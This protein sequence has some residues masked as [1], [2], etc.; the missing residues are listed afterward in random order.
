MADGIN[1]ILNIDLSQF[2]KDYKEALRK[3]GL[4]EV[5]N[6]DGRTRILNPARSSISRTRPPQPTKKPRTALLSSRLRKIYRPPARRGRIYN[7]IGQITAVSGGEG[8]SAEHPLEGASE[9]RE[10]H[11]GQSGED[12]ER[13]QEKADPRGEHEKGG[14]P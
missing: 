12:R 2:T 14:S 8:L 10:L 7:R 13:E 1:L 4:L 5:E 3:N 6:G 11:P 9:V